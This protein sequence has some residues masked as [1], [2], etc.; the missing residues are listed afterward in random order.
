MKK[1]FLFALLVVGYTAQSQVSSN[2]FFYELTMKPKKDSAKVEK[3]MT[4]LDITDK[5]SVYQDYTLI[6]QDSIIKIKVE[7]MQKTKQFKDMSK[8]IV[9]PKFA[10][11]VSK[12]Y[13]DMETQYSESMMNGMT[14]IQ[15]AYNEK[16]NFAWK[17]SNEKQKIGEYNAQ[18]ATTDFGGRKWT[19]WFSN[20]IILQ[21]GPYKFSGLPGLI[22]K[23]SDDGGNYTWELKGNKKV[24]DYQEESYAEKV[25]PGGAGSLVEVN[26]E[27]FEKTF[28]EY[29]KDP[30]SS[31][32][33][34]IPASVMSNKIPGMDK[35]IGEMLKDQEKMLKTFYNSNDNPI[36][37][38]TEKAAKKK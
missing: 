8:D 21:D 36:E 25:R 12:T 9:M 27:K 20:D 7:E 19:A 35:T 31:V 2:R 18:K 22:V 11:K 30:F 3:V 38:P 33:T 14:P 1:L 26:R 34:Q 32:R 16:P 17:I 10:Y 5:K 24:N 37:L 15:L 28:S 4:V 6:A 23:V 13:P 29:K